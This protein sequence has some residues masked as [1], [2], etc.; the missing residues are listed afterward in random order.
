MRPANTL[1]SLVSLEAISIETR[2]AELRAQE[3]PAAKKTRAQRFAEAH[4]WVLQNH[5]DTFRRLAE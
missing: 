3:R 4:A 1:S 5:A 2:P